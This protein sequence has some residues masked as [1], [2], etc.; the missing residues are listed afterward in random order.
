MKPTLDRTHS[1]VLV[2]KFFPTLT[3]EEVTRHFTEIGDAA[4]E[5]GSI[6]V[7]VDLSEAPFASASLRKVAAHEMRTLFR[8]CGDRVV[9]VGHVV[10]TRTARMLLGVVQSLAPPPFPSVIVATA[11]EA[12]V[13]VEGR[14]RARADHPAPARRS[15][16]GPAQSFDAR[17]ATGL[18]RTLV[19]AAR[20]RGLD[21]G[22][23]LTRSRLTLDDLATVEGYVPYRT[24]M[25][26]AEAIAERSGDEAFG[27]H[28]AENFVDASSFGV[29]GF[30]VRSSTTLREAIDR[31]VRYAAVI[32]ESTQMSV[33]YD[34]GGARIIDGPMPPLVWPRH[35]AELSMASF[36][37]LSRKWTGLQFDARAVGFRHAA[38]RDVSEHR[39]IFGCAPVFD[40]AQ[41]FIVIPRH[42]LD[43]QFKYGDRLLGEFFE[44]HL[45]GLARTQGTSPGAL[46]EVRDAMNALL[47]GGAPTLEVVGKKL[48]LSERTLQRR[49]G[50]RGVSFTE[51]LGSVRREAALRGI[52][53]P[54]A[55]V[56]E[57]AFACGF[58]DIKAFRRAFHRWTGVA[59]RE[60]RRGIKRGPV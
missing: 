50:E 36:I 14:L 40:C 6:G 38:P 7:I 51:V 10:R 3:S 45:S 25:W 43:T 22:A 46:A 13:W 17:A 27:L 24:L 54:N 60:Y 33:V 20:A 2:A 55:S 57:L 19:D 44:G 31:T 9:G 12:R 49:L 42:V 32:N 30:A 28:T 41:N 15:S 23:E 11:D 56:Q 26:L 37:T 35:Y 5:L 47:K 1:P 8:R 53:R 59:P 52:E 39:R 58:S 48:G 4:D 34:E 21:V 16:L 18:A 29:A